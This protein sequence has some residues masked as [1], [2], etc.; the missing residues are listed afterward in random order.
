MD[1]NRIVKIN[2]DSERI[3]HPSR[4][5]VALNSC[6][7]QLDESSHL[8][9]RDEAAAQTPHR[10][11]AGGVDY[12]CRLRLVERG[13]SFWTRL[14]PHRLVPGIFIDHAVGQQLMKPCDS[15]RR[16]RRAAQIEAFQLPAAAQRFEMRV[17][18]FLSIIK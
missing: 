15:L 11:R 9:P 17:G 13:G 10:L 16:D 8:A 1:R 5:N 12:P 18:D 2:A 4:K 6:K 3:L 7:S 14:M